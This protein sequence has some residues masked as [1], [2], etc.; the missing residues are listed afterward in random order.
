MSDKFAPIDRSTPHLFP[1]SVEDYLPDD[2]LARFIVDIVDQLDLRSLTGSY[3]GRGGSRAW[4]PAM[5]VSLLLYGYAT[6]TF[7]SRKLEQA[8]RDSVPYRYICAN[9]HPDHDSICAFRKRFLKELEGL[10]VQVLVIARQMGVLKLGTVSLDGTKIK[11]NA[12]K[13]KALS[14][15]Y[16]NK[17]EAQLREE[18]ATLMQL[19]EA[20]D[21]SELPEDLDIPEEIKRREDRLAGI[22]RAKAEIQ[23][24][25]EARHAQEQAEYEAKVAAREKRAQ[26]S[27]KR[28]GG[29]EPKPPTAGPRDKDQVNLTDE[30]SRIM[31]SS[32]GGFEQSYN[33][34]ASVDIDSGLI[35]TGHIT[36]QSNDKREVEPTLAQLTQR[37]EA[38]GTPTG[39]LADTGYFSAANVKAVAAADITPVIAVGRESHNSPLAERLVAPPDNYEPTGDPV[40]DMRRNLRT[41]TGKALYARRKST[42]EPT[43][44]VIKHVQGFRQFLLR[45]VEAAGGEWNLV[46]MAFNLKKLHALGA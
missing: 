25:A 14:W 31:P 17:L 4:H 33:A 34:Q 29:K 2:H 15:Q 19:A 5:M 35:I 42:I 41:A 44:G 20:A 7:S 16:A 40:E 12:N 13:H 22:A 43:F 6:G 45:G 10:F 21:N 24:R 26:E 46:C 3:G 38:L 18:V 8:T 1:P 27:G 9:Q 28:P 36:Q 11:A 32:G 37:G 30:E 23:A 39:L